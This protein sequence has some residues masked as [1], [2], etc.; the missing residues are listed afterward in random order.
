MGCDTPLPNRSTWPLVFYESCRTM[1]I[2]LGG[3][4]DITADFGSAVP[5]SNPGRGT[6]NKREWHGI[7]S[8]RRIWFSG[9]TPACQV[10]DRSP[11]LLIRTEMQ[12][13]TSQDFLNTKTALL[14]RFCVSFR[15]VL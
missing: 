8:R 3:E 5:G 4:M 13:L 10:G 1:Q 9:R 7:M 6:R 15:S 2:R 11:I 12:N 14:S